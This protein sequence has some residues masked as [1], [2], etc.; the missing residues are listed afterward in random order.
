M[1][2]HQT[3]EQRKFLSIIDPYAGNLHRHL[4]SD[5]R[6]YR[7]ITGGHG[8]D[9]EVVREMGADLDRRLR[10]LENK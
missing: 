7:T 3:E 9:F 5:K 2:R 6:G 8:A 10:E 1:N 4:W